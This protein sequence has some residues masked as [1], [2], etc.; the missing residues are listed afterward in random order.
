[1]AANFLMKC[2]FEPVGPEGPLIPSITR[3][4]GRILVLKQ[5]GLLRDYP[6]GFTAGDT[7]F[8]LQE[9]GGVDSIE[10]WERLGGALN[11]VS[12][13]PRPGE[14]Y[15]RL[16]VEPRPGSLNEPRVSPTFERIGDVGQLRFT[17]GAIERQYLI[18]PGVTALA[19]A[20]RL[21]GIDVD[22][23]GFMDRKRV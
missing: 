14:E 17:S 19:G 9:D 2:R 18:G 3:V 1:M 11:S 16:F 23:R 20:G 22:L 12:V 21:R 7:I 15:F 13:R 5:M 10:I 6:R 8:D 4:A